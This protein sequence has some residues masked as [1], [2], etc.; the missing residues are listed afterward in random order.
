MKKDIYESQIKTYTRQLE[1][2]NICLFYNIA[3]YYEFKNQ[4]KDKEENKIFKYDLFYSD[5]NFKESL[6]KEY[7]HKFLT[8]TIELI[9]LESEF[10]ANMGNWI[11]SAKNQDNFMKKLRNDL[12]IK[13]DYETEFE[14]FINKF[15][16]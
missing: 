16:E 8:R 12:A 11:K 13:L 1:I 5:K 2:N 14:D 3:L 7:S 9:K 10:T 15:K 6:I 4:F